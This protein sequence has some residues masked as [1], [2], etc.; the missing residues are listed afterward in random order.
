MRHGPDLEELGGTKID[1]V[2]SECLATKND[3]ATLTTCLIIE[4]TKNFLDHYL[5][6]VK[7]QFRSQRK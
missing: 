3:G 6:E 4:P 5:E 2:D 7:E 1:K